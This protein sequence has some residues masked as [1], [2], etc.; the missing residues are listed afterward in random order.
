MSFT[1]NQQGKR[2]VK[3]LAVSIGTI[4]LLLF[5]MYVTLDPYKHMAL[6]GLK[7]A[8]KSEKYNSYFGIWPLAAGNRT[9]KMINVQYLKPD[10]SI[11]G[12]SCVFSIMDVYHPGFKQYN[13]RPGYNFGYAG[14]NI[15]EIYHTIKHTMVIKKQQLIVV[16]LEFYMFAAD[17]TPAAEFANIPK[18][19]EKN[20]TLKR[21]NTLAT[22]AFS[23][24]WIEDAVDHKIRAGV[25]SLRDTI[26]FPKPA[27][28][29]T[30]VAKTNMTREDYFTFLLGTER[31][32]TSALYP[33]R[34]QQFRFK[35]KDT[36]TLDSFKKI[37]KLARKNNSDLL[38]YISPNNARTY[39]TIRA[40]GLW[41]QYKTWLHELTKIVDEDN[42]TNNN[43]KQYALWDFSQYNSVTMDTVIAHPSKTEA[44]ENYYDTIHYHTPVGNL[45]FNRIFG[46]KENEVPADFG[47]KLTPTTID[48][49]LQAMD[50]K[51]EQ[52]VKAHQ[53][54]VARQIAMVNSLH[55][56]SPHA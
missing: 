36:D 8:R 29:N 50:M 5:A 25:A 13:N 3:L 2:Y 14:A 21:F 56:T 40:M 43:E 54:E 11:F 9:D 48:P 42:Q 33:Y 7:H 55:Q 4:L 12:S 24:L 22:K 6:L 49:H 31:M 35:N 32:Q 38:V 37:V 41:P 52:Y 27:Q 26:P 15:G 47:V 16:G 46:M 10:S 20:Y 19:Y 1:V 28:T 39:E 34:W 53:A 18:S 17:K 23:T 45:V 44:F 51:R 30:V